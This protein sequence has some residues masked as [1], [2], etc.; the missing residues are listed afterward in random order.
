MLISDL[1]KYRND[2]ITKITE[3]SVGSSI[4]R[5]L[6]LIENLLGHHTANNSFEKLNQV[7]DEYNNIS[8]QFRS[9]QQILQSIL[10]DIDTIID[11]E[12]INNFDHLSLKFLGSIYSHEF[13]LDHSVNQLIQAYIHKHA[14]HFFPALQL[15]C[16]PRSKVLT[17]ELVANDPLYL[18]DF[19]QENIENISSQFNDIYYRRLRKY[20][21]TDHELTQLPQNQFGLVFSWMQFNYA[22]SALVKHYLE[23]VY[24]LLRPGGCFLFSYNNCDLLESCLVAE[25]GAMSYISK[26]NLV[27]TCQN[28]G[29]EIVEMHDEPNSDFH[30]KYISWFEIRKP[31]ELSTVKRR[32]VIGTIHQK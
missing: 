32:Q 9:V 7:K 29:Y 27:N 4:D 23:R 1:L 24:N 10:I 13:S 31:G 19:D 5:D 30:V 18:C 2:L 17:N 3:L 6:S 16:T 25:T 28:L 15:G 11:T 12:S 22:N 14:D 8:N 26:R 20:V 21:L